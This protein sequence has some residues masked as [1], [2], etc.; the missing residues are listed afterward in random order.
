MTALSR[1]EVKNSVDK[2][3][4]V[5][6]GCDS[7]F[8]KEKSV[9]AA[10]E[11]TGGEESLIKLSESVKANYRRF[12]DARRKLITSIE[13]CF[14][15]VTFYCPRRSKFVLDEVFRDGQYLEFIEEITDELDSREASLPHVFDLGANFG[16]FPLLLEEYSDL[17]LYYNL[18]EPFPEN[19]QYLRKNLS[20]NGVS[21]YWVRQEAV[22][23]Q[24]GKTQLHHTDSWTGPTI[25]DDELVAEISEKSIKIS[26]V[27]LDDHEWSSVDLVK[28][29]IEGAEEAA[30]QGMQQTIERHK[31]V[32]VCSF[33]HRTNDLDSIKDLIDVDGSY[34]F[35][36]SEDTEFLLG[37]SK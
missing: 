31:P 25:Q 4:S 13:T 20:N 28:I 11:R 35:K 32:V 15:D 24:S 26:T 37:V 1:K 12:N 9:K 3:S 33:E 16:V 23:N 2:L 14:T 34:S 6:T 10:T 8:N 29:D 5:R 30:L 19:L 18:Y 27:R 7:N 22:S 17:E 36:I 21:N